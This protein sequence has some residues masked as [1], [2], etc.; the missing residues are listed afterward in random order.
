MSNREPILR[1]AVI[2]DLH[3]TQI[4]IGMREVTQ[5]RIRLR[6]KLKK[7][8]DKFLAKRMIPVVLGPGKRQYIFDHHHLALALHHEGLLNVFTTI[9][10]DLSMLTPDAFWFYMDNRSLVHPFNEHGAR[11]N[12]SDIPESVNGLVD[13]P[14]RSLAWEVRRRGGYA[15]DTTPFSDF[16][17]ANFFRGRISGK[18]LERSFRRA[19]QKAFRLGRSSSAAYLP[20][21]CGP[22]LEE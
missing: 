18:L 19:S 15:K 20:G 21:W 9:V 5:R 17:W 1:P 2:A 3:P 14:F 8:R 12:Y 16:L 22:L 11:C 10:R 6:A 7:G 4:T 13:D